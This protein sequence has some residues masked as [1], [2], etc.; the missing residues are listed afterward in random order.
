MEASAGEAELVWDADT[1]CYAPDMYRAEATVAGVLSRL[2]AQPLLE[3]PRTASLSGSQRV[4]RWIDTNEKSTSKALSL[5]A[6]VKYCRQTAA[7]LSL[8]GHLQRGRS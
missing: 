4:E 2:A 3:P 6:S 7:G 1:R 5:L 8:F